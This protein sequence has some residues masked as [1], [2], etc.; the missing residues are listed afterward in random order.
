M[1]TSGGR[2][3]GLGQGGAGQGGSGQGDPSS[4]T[5]PGDLIEAPVLARFVEK[6]KLSCHASEYAP[7]V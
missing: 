2:S 1:A 3:G 4:P 7:G 5:L 6:E